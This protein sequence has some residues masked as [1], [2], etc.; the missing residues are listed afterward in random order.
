MLTI[1]GEPLVSII[2]STES[3]RI[4]TPAA[5]MHTLAS[6]TQGAAVNP[7]WKVEAA[8]GVAG[9]VHHIDAEQVWTLLEGTAVVTIDGERVALAAGDTAVVPAD[10]ERQFTSGAN[11]FT[12]VVTG[13][14]G[15]SAY[16]PGR[17]HEKVAPPWTV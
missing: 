6:P 4:E 12:A 14:A 9:P 17:P 7:I 2:R 13:P 10:A 16:L 8:A 11:G 3:R 1:L 5:V 15:M